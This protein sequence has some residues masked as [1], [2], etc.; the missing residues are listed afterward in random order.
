MKSNRPGICT[1]AIKLRQEL[2]PLH[3]ITQRSACSPKQMGL[4]NLKTLWSL[5]RIVVIKPFLWPDKSQG[6]GALWDKEWAVWTGTVGVKCKGVS[7]EKNQEQDQSSPYC[8]LHPLPSSGIFR[9]QPEGAKVWGRGTW[10]QRMHAALVG[11]KTTGQQVVRWAQ[12]KASWHVG[13]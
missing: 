1:Q 3:S 4:M 10:V 12:E 2:Y 5:E 9:C 11:L 13:R 8:V 7:G 6:K